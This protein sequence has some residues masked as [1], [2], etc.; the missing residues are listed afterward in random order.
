MPEKEFFY[1]QAEHLERQNERLAL[2][3]KKMSQKVNGEFFPQIGANLLLEDG[4]LNMDAFQKKRKNGPYRKTR[5]GDDPTDLGE[6]TIEHDKD[7]VTGL[8]ENRAYR[9][10]KA[11]NTVAIGVTS[12]QRFLDLFEKQ[13]LNKPGIKAEMVV[14]L[15]LHKVLGKE[16]LV[17]RSSYFDDNKNGVDNLVVDRRTGNVVCTFDEVNDDVGGRKMARKS[18]KV[19]T[20]AQNGGSSVKYGLTFVDTPEGKKLERCKLDNIPLFAVALG[21]NDLN[22]LLET[23]DFDPDAPCSAVELQFFAK[24]M[25]ALEDQQKILAE[26]S[27]Q[28]D[29]KRHL[30]EFKLSFA[31]MQELGKIKSK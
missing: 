8:E 17:V 6:D 5:R 27:T 30:E 20:T 25:K 3:L 22:A 19:V 2:G 23:V 31:R 11:S 18:E 14:T 7:F 15:L 16:F 26:H 21:M 29:A 13:E 1:S 9:E 24:L 12:P 10:V 28:E 4:A